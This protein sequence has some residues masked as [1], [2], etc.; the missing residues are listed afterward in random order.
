M[1]LMR[2]VELF[3]EALGFALLALLA[4]VKL[5]AQAG[6]LVPTRRRDSERLGRDDRLCPL[7]NCLLAGIAAEGDIRVGVG[8][9]HFRECAGRGD[10]F[11]TASITRAC[12]AALAG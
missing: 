4:V 7:R 9:Q 6:L 3:S 1:F 8:E 5:A 2:R 11:P 10:D 12:A